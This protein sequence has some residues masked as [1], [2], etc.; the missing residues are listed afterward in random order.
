MIP[1]GVAFVLVLA[2]AMAVLAAIVV[3]MY[4]LR[5]FISPDKRGIEVAQDPRHKADW[6]DF[7]CVY[8]AAVFILFVILALAAAYVL[9]S[10]PP[11][12]F[13]K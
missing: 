13:N 11:M 5:S 7:C 12:R 1:P 2:G 6:G 4:L 9:F 3:G 8:G 10:N